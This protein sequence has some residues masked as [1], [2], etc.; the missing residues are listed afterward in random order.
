MLD[1]ESYFRIKSLKYQASETL[2][3]YLRQQ[4]GWDAFFTVTFAS[5]IRFPWTAIDK[6]AKALLRGTHIGRAF[7]AA[8]QHL[9]GNWHTHGLASFTPLLDGA[10]HDYDLQMSF[11]LKSFNKL[12]WSSVSNPRTVGGCTGYC[13]KYLNKEKPVEWMIYGKE[14]VPLDNTKSGV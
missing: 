2:S 8:E 10:F 13:A 11:A 12:G 4:P 14:W 9:S 5:P 6:T 7:V 1:S 3:L